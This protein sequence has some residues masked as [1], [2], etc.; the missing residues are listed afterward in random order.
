MTI[1]PSG[2]SDRPWRPSPDPEHDRPSTWIGLWSDL[3][4]MLE[5]VLGRQAEVEHLERLLIKP[6]MRIVYCFAG[7]TAVAVTAYAMRGVTL[8][9]GAVGRIGFPW[10]AGGSGFL[11]FGSALAIGRVRRKRRRRALTNA[12]TSAV[13]DVIA[14]PVEPLAALPHPPKRNKGHTQNRRKR[15]RH[16]R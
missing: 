12:P 9:L 8:D 3:I 6:I 10:V 15:R 1:E 2:T 5:R 16:R 13:I 7:L 14:T 4:Q 11:I